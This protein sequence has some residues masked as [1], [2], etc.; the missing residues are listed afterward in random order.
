MEQSIHIG[1]LS[2]FED[3]EIT[4]VEVGG[5]RIAVARVDGEVFAVEDRCTH[6]DCALSE[7]I[8]E[9]K[10]VLCPCHGSEFDLTTGEALALPAKTPVERFTTQIEGEDVYVKI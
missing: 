2:E 6:K 7:G 8:L 9:G 5:R 1:K 4:P 3:D 10:A